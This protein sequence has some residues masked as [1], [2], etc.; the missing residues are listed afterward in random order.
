MNWREKSHARA[1]HLGHL[2]ASA[3]SILWAL[4]DWFSPPY[5]MA[6]LFRFWALKGMK[7]DICNPSQSLNRSDL[8][9]ERGV[10]SLK[11]LAS[12]NP[13]SLFVD[14]SILLYFLNILISEYSS[15]QKFLITVHSSKR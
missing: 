9:D 12:P 11:G 3:R 2:L 1:L 4:P 7:D 8:G 13:P 5:L 6:L 14:G 10:S 15:C